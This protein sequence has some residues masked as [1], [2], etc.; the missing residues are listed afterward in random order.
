MSGFAILFLALASQNT[1]PVPTPVPVACAENGHGQFD[2][3]VGEW[4]VYPNGASQLIAYSRIEKLYGGCAIRENWMPVKGTGGGSLNA[5]DPSTKRWQQKWIG[6]QPG[7]IE[8]DGGLVD[9]AMVLTGF[10]AAVNGPGQDA[11][12]R[13]RYIPQSDG[14]VRQHGEQ[15]TDHGLTW[16]TNFDFIYKKRSVQLPAG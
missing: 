12:I 10:W 4:D 1:A 2:F 15:S 6:S 5:Y 8:F 13:M 7:I 14:S 9:G 3:W 16:T 11:L